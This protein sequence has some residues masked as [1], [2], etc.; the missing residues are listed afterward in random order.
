MQNH[1]WRS[2]DEKFLK[3]QNS[4]SMVTYF[5]RHVSQMHTTAC[6][7][8][9]AQVHAELA[10]LRT[11][12]KHAQDCAAEEASCAG[13]ALLAAQADTEAAAAAGK[14][15]SSPQCHRSSLTC[16]LTPATFAIPAGIT[17]TDTK[18]PYALCLC[19]VIDA[20]RCHCSSADGDRLDIVSMHDSI[21]PNIGSK[22]TAHQLSWIIR[23]SILS[24]TERR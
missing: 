19:D 2:A 8:E 9:L 5:E 1:I 16:G 13:K 11:S 3:G 12:L 24:T 15:F 14:P 20:A 23:S 4:P 17:K 21:L 22:M 6:M 10:V 7:Q 18:L